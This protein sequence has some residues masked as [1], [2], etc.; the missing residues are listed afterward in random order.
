[1][2]YHCRNTFCLKE[3]QPKPAIGGGKVDV[4]LLPTVCVAADEE[5]SCD[6]KEATK[7]DVF[8]H[9]HQLQPLAPSPSDW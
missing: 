5:Q 1:M 3:F 6:I 7:H 4:P 8:L 2:E 9:Q